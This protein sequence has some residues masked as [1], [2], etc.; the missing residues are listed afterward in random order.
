MSVNLRFYDTLYR[1]HL[2]GIGKT[3]I[4]Y[5]NLPDITGKIETKLIFIDVPNLIIPAYHKLYPMSFCFLATVISIFIE[6]NVFTHFL[7]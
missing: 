4:I 6:F 2:L 1:R 5:Y 7:E 3:K